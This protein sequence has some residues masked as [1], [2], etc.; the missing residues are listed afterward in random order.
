[1]VFI[2]QG[3]GTRIIMMHFS[4][5]HYFLFFLSITFA[6]EEESLIPCP[7]LRGLVTDRNVTAIFRANESNDDLCNVMNF[8]QSRLPGFY[9]YQG[10]GGSGGDQGN[11]G[12]LDT[13]KSLRDSGDSCWPAVMVQCPDGWLIRCRPGFACQEKGG[14]WI[15]GTPGFA[16]SYGPLDWREA[17]C[18][19]L[20][21]SLEEQKI[22]QSAASPE[23]R[24][25]GGYSNAPAS[26]MIYSTCN[27]PTCNGPNPWI[28]TSTTPCPVSM[29]M[30]V[31]MSPPTPFPKYYSAYSSASSACSYPLR[32]QSSLSSP[33]VMS[34]TNYYYP[35]TSYYYAPTPPDEQ[36]FS[37]F[38]FP[39]TG[40]AI[41]TGTVTIPTSYYYY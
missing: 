34:V 32:M 28:V 3:K 19:A 35:P 22:G 37:S 27:G 1:M 38:L 14:P 17:K 25:Q 7:Y 33:S 26:S 11:T 36:Q 5:I 13:R 41:A 20:N 8:C 15:D 2:E 30:T 24:Y 39:P 4:T 23:S 16:V 9:C 18:R 31:A 29:T 12:G 40:T 6:V 10:E 21:E